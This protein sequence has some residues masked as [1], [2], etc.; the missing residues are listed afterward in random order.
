MRV[1]RWLFC[2]CLNSEKLFFREM[3]LKVELFVSVWRG[4]G[5]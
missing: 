1:V 5:G 3:T 4:R 2:V